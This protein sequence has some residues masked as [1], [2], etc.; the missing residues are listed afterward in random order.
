MPLNVRSSK[1]TG[2]VDL[3]IVRRYTDAVSVCC[4][5]DLRVVLVH[6]GFHGRSH[7]YSYVK[8]KGVWWKTVDYVVTEVYFVKY[9]V[10]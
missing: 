8:H 7:L 9:Q 4:Q 3:P 2:C 1:N 5:Y 10:A 6:D